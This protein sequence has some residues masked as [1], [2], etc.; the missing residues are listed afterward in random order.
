VDRE[1]RDA[2][3]GSVHFDDRVPRGAALLA[4]QHAPGDAQVAIEPRVPQ[5]AAVVL[6]PDLRVVPREAKRSDVRRGGV[7]RR[8][9]SVISRSRKASRSGIESE[10]PWAERCA[11]RERKSLRNGVHHANAVVWGP[12]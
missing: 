7:E 2:H 11:R 5:P 10:G 3:H 1:R 4:H 8:R 6:R 9:Q 12:V